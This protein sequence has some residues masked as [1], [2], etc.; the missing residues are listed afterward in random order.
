MRA[1]EFEFRYRFWINGLIFWA[2]FSCYPI[3]HVNA[4]VAIAQWI[5]GMS[6]D[7]HSAHFRA[8]VQLVFA[9]AAALTFAAAMIRTWGT[10]YLRSDV[11][12][13]LDLHNEALVADGPYRYVR[14]PLY[15]GT[16]LMGAGIGLMASRLGWFVLVILLY[17]FHRRLIGREEAELRKTQGESYETYCARV[18]RFWPAPWPRVA[19]GR[20][21]PRWK[22]AFQGE[23]LIWAL[24]VVVAFFAVTLQQHAAYEGIGVALT[25]YAIVVFGL[26]RWRHKQAALPR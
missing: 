25:V 26:R 7:L 3:D 10:A 8:V 15:F 17:F 5:T 2:A 24:A 6:A 4:A 16:V 18:P 11:V 19:A 9:S 1:T 12:H 23:S 22:Q 20:M 21:K 14:N 13:D